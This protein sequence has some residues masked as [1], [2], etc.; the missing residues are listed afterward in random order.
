[1]DSVAT[2]MTYSLILIIKNYDERSYG[3]EKIITMMQNEPVYDDYI[4]F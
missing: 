2:W 3:H 1:M 4:N